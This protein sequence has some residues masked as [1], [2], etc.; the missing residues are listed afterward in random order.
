MGTVG[1]FCAFY[2][3]N[4]NPNSEFVSLSKDVHEITVTIKTWIEAHEA[5]CY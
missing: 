3:C 4:F 5:N 1:E 2:E